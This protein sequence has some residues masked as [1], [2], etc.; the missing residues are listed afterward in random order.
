MKKFLTLSSL[1]LILA[2]VVACSPPEAL[3]ILLV[4][5]VTTATHLQM[6]KQVT[7]AT[8]LQT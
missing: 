5:L 8:H 2:A 4:V 1:S 6:M 3:P 7:T